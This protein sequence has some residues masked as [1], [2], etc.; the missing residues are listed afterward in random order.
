MKRSAAG[1]IL[2]YV[3]VLEF[4]AGMSLQAA[5]RARYKPTQEAVFGALDTNGD[6]TITPEEGPATSNWP[7]GLFKI[8]DLDNDGKISQREFR[9]W[10]EAERTKTLATQLSDMTFTAM[11]SNHDNRIDRKSEWFGT[12]KDFKRYDA[13]HDGSITREEAQ[14]GQM[15]LP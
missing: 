5:E 7:T 14:Y 12:E 4:G 13:D 6:G 15:P 11:D 8:R 1:R 10:K 2:V 3:T 9:T